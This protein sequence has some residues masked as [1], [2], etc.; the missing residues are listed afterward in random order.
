MLKIGD[1]QKYLKGEIFIILVPL[2][3]YVFFY[4]FH[5]IML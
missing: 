5:K 3:M 1:W 2:K 4:I